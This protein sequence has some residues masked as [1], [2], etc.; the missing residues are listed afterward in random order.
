MN[1]VKIEVWWNKLGATIPKNIL[2]LQQWQN[3]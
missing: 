3:W 1:R 2:Q